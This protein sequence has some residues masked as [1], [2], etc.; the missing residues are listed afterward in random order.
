MG[1][2]K[3]VVQGIEQGIE[4]GA[5]IQATAIAKKLLAQGMEPAQIAA[6]TE[7]PLAEV[8]VLAQKK[9]S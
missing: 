9:D 3:G 5:R 7:L 6:I 1:L 8:E 2:D 4:Q